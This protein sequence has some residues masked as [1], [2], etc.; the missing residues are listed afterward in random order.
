MV[1]KKRRKK[2][3]RTNGTQKCI[4][5][6]IQSKL[7]FAPH[8]CIKLGSEKTL[9]DKRKRKASLHDGYTS[10]QFSLRFNNTQNISTSFQ[11]NFKRIQSFFDKQSNRLRLQASSQRSAKATWH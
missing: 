10:R 1:T 6:T 3:K 2:K 7:A 9:F 11:I 4:Q 8:Y 5:Q